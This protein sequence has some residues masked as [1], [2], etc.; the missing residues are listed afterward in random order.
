M[1]LDKTCLGNGE[2]WTFLTNKDGKGGKDT[3][4]AA[5]PGTKNDEIISILASAMD[6]SVRHRGKEVTCDLSSSMMLVAAEVFHYACIVNDRFHAQ[7]IYNETVDEIA[8]TYAASWFPRKTGTA[9]P[10]PA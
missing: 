2:V 10:R 5:I 7:R 6:K 4:A 3:Q 8:S 1:S 9:S